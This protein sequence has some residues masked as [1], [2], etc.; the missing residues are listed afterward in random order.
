[1]VAWLVESDGAITIPIY[2]VVEKP[3]NDA[4]KGRL[5]CWTLSRSHAEQIVNDHARIEA[6]SGIVDDEPFDY[7][8][9]DALRCMLR[10]FSS[11]MKESTKRS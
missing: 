5:I 1:M 7:G 10:R 9:A 3:A 4:G 2:R 11:E 6:L 8:K